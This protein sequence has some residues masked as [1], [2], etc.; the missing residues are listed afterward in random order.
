[1]KPSSAKEKGRTLQKW[2]RDR[3]LDLFKGLLAPDDVRSTSSGSNGEDI[4]LSS[5]ARALIPFSVECKNL[6]AIAA[7]KWY[8][9]AKGNSGKHEPLLVMK[10]NRKKPLAVLDAEYFFGMVKEL[11]DKKAK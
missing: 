2:V 4:L 9:Q 1:M 11:Q 5:A 3:I 10:A 6:Q 7:Y 8:E